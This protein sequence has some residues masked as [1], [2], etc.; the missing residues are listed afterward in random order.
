MSAI[1]QSDFNHLS[2]GDKYD[3]FHQAWPSIWDSAISVESNLCN[4]YSLLRQIFN[5]WWVGNYWVKNNTLT[6]GVFQGDPACTLI[7]FGHGVCGKCWKDATTLIVPN[8]HEFPG[9]IACSA[10]SNSEIVIPIFNA[11]SEVIG[12]LD[13]DSKEFNNFDPIDRMQLEFFCTKLAALL[14]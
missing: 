3:Y 6:L 1:I 7:E 8:V 5:W 11:N 12:V 13:I 9:H 4:C 10:Y 2:K 14:Q